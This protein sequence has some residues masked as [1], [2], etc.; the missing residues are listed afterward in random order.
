MKSWLE[1]RSLPAW[2]VLLV[3]V[4][5]IGLNFGAAWLPLASPYKRHLAAGMLQLV[6]VTLAAGSLV[7]WWVRRGDRVLD[8]MPSR[9][10]WIAVVAGMAA[11]VAGLSYLSLFRHQAL[12][13]GIW[14]LGYYGQLTWELSNLEFPRS[15]I[16]HDSLWGNHA[17]FILIVAAPFLWL[18]SDPIDRKS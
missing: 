13:T 7:V 9:V 6:L 10:A 17:T 4:A 12:L 18:V 2:G 16:W 14:D 5:C 8:A 1:T 15:S 3:I 11:Y